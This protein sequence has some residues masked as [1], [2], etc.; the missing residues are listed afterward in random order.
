MTETAVPHVYVRPNPRDLR[1]IPLDTDSA[2]Q[3]IAALTPL[4]RGVWFALRTH[5][6]LYGE[7]PAAPRQ[8][9]AIGG[10]TPRTFEKMAP[11]LAPLFDHDS[12]G[13]WHDLDLEEERDRRLDLAPGDRPSLAPGFAAPRPVA[14]SL[15]E[16]RRQAGRKGSDKRW[17]DRRQRLTIVA[18]GREDDPAGNLAPSALPQAMANAIANGMANAAD[19]EGSLP[20]GLPSDSSSPMASASGAQS[21]SD[22]LSSFYILEE[23]EESDGRTDAQRVDA[24][25]G[26][27]D[28]AAMASDGKPMPVAIAPAAPLEGGAV[29]NGMASGLA[30]GDA[31]MAKSPGELMASVSALGLANGAA[32]G[33][34]NGGATALPYTV[35]EAL[36]AAP[37]APAAAPPPGDAVVIEALVKAGGDKISPSL[38]TP[39][40]IAP[41]R[42]WLGLGADLT[43]HVMPAV[44]DCTRSLSQPLQSFKAPF[45]RQA[46]ESQRKRDRG[47][48][49]SDVPLSDAFASKV[50]VA[51]DS[52]QWRAWCE[53]KRK[54][55]MF[56]FERASDKRRGTYVDD[57]WPP[58]VDPTLYDVAQATEPAGSG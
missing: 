57:E 47:A 51:V 6:W 45:L 36:G 22:R 44:A 2:L 55:T 54:R 42:A 28:P 41:V 5:I 29:A 32:T 15:S 31:P 10:I 39:A 12:I 43:R 40:G 27:T 16:V 30:N 49:K 23:I 37:P 14:P 24:P 38:L 53:Y 58:G 48:A 8:L 11:A 50:F 56:S 7:L 9:A 3:A 46:V 34:A 26:K 18:G 25:V 35:G 1:E 52:P 4:Q 19:G 33:M 21:P 17:S 20:A 13:R